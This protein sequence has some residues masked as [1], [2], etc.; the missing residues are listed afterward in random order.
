LL[1]GKAQVFQR[2]LRVGDHGL[3]AGISLVGT[4]RLDTE[5]ESALPLLVFVIAG[6]LAFPSAM[7]VLGLYESQRRR[8]LAR[9]GG[10]LALGAALTATVL[11]QVCLALARPQWSPYAASIALAQLVAFTTAR[12]AIYTALRIGRRHGRNVR[13]V[14]VIGT[15]PRA[16]A[17]ASEVASNPGWGL[18]IVAFLDEYQ[19]LPGMRLEANAVRKLTDFPDVVR[20]H[21]V[22][23]VV[24]ALPR[25]LLFQI[26]PIAAE[27]ALIGVPMSVLSDLFAD[28][29]PASQTVRYGRLPAIQ[30]A[31]VVYDGTDLFLKRCL[32]VALGG[33]LL[34]ALAPLI[35]AAML[36][37]HL[38]SPG[39]VLYRQVR[40]GRNGRPFVML[41]LRSMVEDADAKRAALLE[42]NEVSGPVFKM[43]NDPRVTAVGRFLRRWSIDET[44]QL[45]N[46]VRG[47]M[48]LV[49][50]RPPLPHE[51][52]MYDSW[53]RR[54]ISVRPGLTCLWQIHGR[55]RV[56]FAEWVD[57]D[58]HYIDHW[59]LGLD[60]RILLRTPLAVLRRDGAS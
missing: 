34:A 1:R 18:R 26:E 3:A 47:D 7:G 24:V 19:P 57:L 28:K 31:D 45:W 58:L 55:S 50:P 9:I 41:K 49:G 43:R 37:I 40:L 54:R 30:F 10:Q 42:L 6:T 17:F 52:D 53:H 11:V 35:G 60:L 25:S 59:S 5:A 23:E 32:D 4:H 51:V 14:V 2:L 46:V 21:P 12:L 22:D 15:G 38:T 29:L 27:C 16:R 39:P 33:A 56:Q 44:P 48:S 8:S 36:A 13:H 20:Q